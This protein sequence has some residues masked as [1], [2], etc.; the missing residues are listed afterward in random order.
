M[1]RWTDEELRELTTLWPTH[2]VSQLVE[3]LHRPR[4]AIRSK[5]KRLRLDGMRPHNPSKDVEADNLPKRRPLKPDH[6][7]AVGTLTK[8]IHHPTNAGCWRFLIL[9]Q[10]GARRVLLSKSA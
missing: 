2:S 4:A 1:S 7:A 3:Q 6:T 5:A 10:C 9:T 8:L